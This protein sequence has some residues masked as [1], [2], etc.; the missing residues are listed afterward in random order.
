MGNLTKNYKYLKKG[1]TKPQKL[2]VLR[3]TREIL[4]EPGSWAKHT[5]WRPWGKKDRPSMC[6]GGACQYA[7]R[8]LG[9]L[10]PPRGLLTQNDLLISTEVADEVS[11]HDL[12]VK[13]GYNSIP[14]FNDNWKTTRKE[15]LALIDER[16]E[17]LEAQ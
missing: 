8:E 15:V 11:L 17:L 7:A 16:I 12:V 9:Y 5:F 4:D 2:K 1:L 6:L 3:R 10:N 14:E 13:K